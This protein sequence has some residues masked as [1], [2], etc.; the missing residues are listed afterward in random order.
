[1]PWHRARR[2]NI[3]SGDADSRAACQLRGGTR[4]ASAA[5]PPPPGEIGDLC[6]LEGGVAPVALNAWCVLGEM[7]SGTRQQEVGEPP[8]R[9]VCLEG[10][11]SRHSG[12]VLPPPHRPC[13]TDLVDSLKK[14]SQLPSQ[15]ERV[16]ALRDWRHRQC[17]P[18]RYADYDLVVVPSQVLTLVT[19]F[20][21][22]L[23]QWVVTVFVSV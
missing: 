16:S 4:S 23:N 6:R 22:S 7:H 9:P 2:S 5:A 21:A 1:M 15:P 12:C 3:D 10:H 20:S 14:P 18:N 8:Y 13:L 11:S 17:G 19:F